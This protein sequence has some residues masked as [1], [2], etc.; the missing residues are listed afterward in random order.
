[1]VLAGTSLT[2]LVAYYIFPYNWS[3]N[4]AMTLGSILS[5][6]DPVAVSTL[7]EEVGAPPRLKVHISGESL[8]ND[9]SAMVFYTIFSSLFLYEYG[10]GGEEIDGGQGVKIF[11]RMALGGMCIGIA[12]GLALLIILYILNRKLNAEENVVQVVATITIAYLTFYV[13]EPVAGTSG[14]IA[15]IFCGFVTKAFGI[16]MIND[17]HM[18][19]NFWIL[20]ENILNSVLFTLGGLTWGTVIANTGSREGHW[21]GQDWGYLILLYVLLTVIRFLLFFGF[22]PLYSRM[23]LKSR[24]QE[25]F[26][27]AYGGLRGAVGIALA[28]QLDATVFAETQNPEYQAFATKL[29]GMVGGIAFMTLFINGSSAGPL[30]LKLGLANDTRMRKR[31][32]ESFDSA[33]KEHM[34]DSLIQILT[35]PIYSDVDFAVIRA[36]N[37]DLADLTAD[38]IRE[39]AVRNKA[40]VPAKDYMEPYLANV[41]KCLDPNA[42]TEDPGIISVDTKEDEAEKQTAEE[43]EIEVAEE[44]VSKR[45]G[46]GEP[47]IQC[48]PE[49]ASELLI[50][51]RKNF[52]EMLRS[53]YHK[54]IEK[55]ELDGRE[56]FL[57][58]AIIEGLEFTADEVSRGM[59]LD[60]FIMVK[61][62]TSTWTEP[63]LRHLSRA[64]NVLSVCSSGRGSQACAKVKMV[65]A[66]YE[67]V[68]EEV[69][70]AV[71]V[72]R[73]H[74]MA[75]VEFH[76]EYCNVH[77]VGRM[78]KVI[79]YESQKQVRLA[80]HVLET[81]PEKDVIISHL[82]CRILF[83]RSAR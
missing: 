58:H 23:G 13:A 34:L 40:S 76:K 45:S 18:M 35:K 21:T 36:H 51:L 14:V 25:C 52:V 5:A 12:F 70:L 16:D 73:A 59:P 53:A 67:K 11:V 29:F 22:Y 39:A 63:C 43:G 8:L 60:D 79:L 48:I 47:S 15:T 4:L 54:M 17:L 83:A 75:Q 62:V 61:K 27:Q 41:L 65:S 55:E 57:T 31:I 78:E 30:L 44:D 77:G 10:I 69:H 38:D 33:Y 82:V 72:V 80:E 64:L 26:F 66:S 56:G 49:E 32:L 68:I 9:G 42:D 81:C 2:A 7:L 28:I 74:E 19:E 3:F 46:L 71:A 1:M 6:T 24:W 20:V 37:G 50:E